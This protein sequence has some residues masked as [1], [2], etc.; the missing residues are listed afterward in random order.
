MLSEVSVKGDDTIALH[1]D[2]LPTAI[3]ALGL[4]NEVRRQIDFTRPA[5]PPARP[6]S[7]LTSVTTT[8]DGIS[9]A[10]SGKNVVLAN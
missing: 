6:E 10:A 4:E 2:K 3:T 9:V 8:P 5:Q 7:R 1:A